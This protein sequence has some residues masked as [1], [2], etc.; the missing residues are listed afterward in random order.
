MASCFVVTISERYM[1]SLRFCEPPKC[2]VKV[3]NIKVNSS[4]D[5]AMKHFCRNVVIAQ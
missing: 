3:L 4:N 1:V 5:S 2:K